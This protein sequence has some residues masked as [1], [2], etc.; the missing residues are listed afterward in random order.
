MKEFLERNK[1]EIL[2]IFGTIIVSH[3]LLTD[4]NIIEKYLVISSDPVIFFYI[5]F[6]LPGF[7]SALLSATIWKNIKKALIIGVITSIIWFIWINIYFLMTFSIGLY[8]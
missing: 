7:F 1:K 6:I 2:I 5:Y 8:Y 4:H 3:F